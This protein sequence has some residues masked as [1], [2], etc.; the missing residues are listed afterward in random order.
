MRQT[1]R[2]LTLFEDPR[3]QRGELFVDFLCVQTA[4]VDAWGD[5]QRTQQYRAGL[6]RVICLSQCGMQPLLNQMFKHEINDGPRIVDL[7]G[8]SEERRVGNEGTARW[9]G[10]RGSEYCTAA[11]TDR[12]VD[13]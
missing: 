6:P 5:A 11:L 9:G 10:W 3:T 1:C 7:I 13:V 2:R 12:A 4:A 8:R